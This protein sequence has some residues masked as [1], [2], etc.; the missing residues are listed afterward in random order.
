[1]TR[2]QIRVLGFV[3]CVLAL[4]ADS[5]LGRTV[6]LVWD[7]NPAGENVTGYMV[8]YG[9]TSRFSPGFSAYDVE[10][11]V[12][13]VTQWRIATEDEV[14]Y[15]FAVKAYNATPIYSDYS[16]EVN[17]VSSRRITW[18][19]GSGSTSHAAGAGS[20]TWGP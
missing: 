10:I 2:R 15:Y 16:E 11:D 8:Y 7:P 1:M 6:T 14:L 4:F 17:S 20:L 12:G 3:G 13:N 19:S 5:A 18:A 9:T